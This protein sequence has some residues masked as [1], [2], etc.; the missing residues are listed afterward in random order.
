MGIQRKVV[1]QQP[2]RQ[3]SEL[4]EKNEKI[5]ELLN[6][7]KVPT[8]LMA[9]KEPRLDLGTGD[10]YPLVDVLERIAELVGTS[11]KKKPAAVKKISPLA[12]AETKGD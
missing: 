1:S 9:W 11:K 2:R 5:G 10:C 12:G 6:L 4:V 7:E 3:Q 8:H